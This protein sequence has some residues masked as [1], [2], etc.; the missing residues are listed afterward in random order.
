ME[1]LELNS[2]VQQ[3]SSQQSSEMTTPRSHSQAS[4]VLVFVGGSIFRIISYILKIR[5]LSHGFRLYILYAESFFY[6][7]LMSPLET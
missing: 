4:C 6:L 7:F 2:T 3:R 5:P 1:Q